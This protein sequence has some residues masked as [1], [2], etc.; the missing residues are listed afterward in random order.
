MKVGDMIKM[1]VPGHEELRPGAM[2]GVI[3]ESLLHDA[4]TAKG[5]Q[6]WWFVLRND[7]GRIE[8]FHE[9]WCEV[10]SENR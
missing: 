4:S 9:N 1:R 5:P 2:Y 6:Q 3:V 10:I 8:K 7:T